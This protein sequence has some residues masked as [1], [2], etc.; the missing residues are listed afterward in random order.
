MITVFIWT[1]TDTMWGHASLLVDGGKPTGSIYLS[2]WP[3]QSVGVSLCS[4]A[5]RDRTFNEDVRGELRQPEHRI[6]LKGL[7]ETAIKRW[8]STSRIRRSREW[9]T[10]GPNCS[11]L[12]AHALKAGGGD[13]HVDFQRGLSTWAFVWQPM[14]VFHYATSI[15]RGLS[16]PP[17][18][19][20]ADGRR[21]PGDLNAMRHVR[22]VGVI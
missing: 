5:H 3:R 7:N 19:S 10:L 18:R 22:G 21:S 9:C 15:R 11:T 4:P 1:P 20:V 13:E 14:D 2:W 12:V 16:N 6:R 17:R 8:W